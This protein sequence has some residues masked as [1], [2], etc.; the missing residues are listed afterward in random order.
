MY[1]KHCGKVIADD[2]KFCQ[3]CGAL[4]EV[5]HH[6]ILTKFNNL[7]YKAKLLLVVYGMWV[8]LNLYLLIA[9]GDYHGDFFPFS[10]TRVDYYDLSEFIVYVFGLPLLIYGI[11][12]IRNHRKE[13]KLQQK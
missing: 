2:S 9:G 7:S 4:Q 5:E 11:R 6:N 8:L 3:Y 13:K 10:S 12:L 1:C